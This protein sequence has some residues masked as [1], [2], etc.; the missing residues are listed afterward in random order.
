MSPIVAAARSPQVSSPVG[1]GRTEGSGEGTK[2]TVPT[3]IR[4][5]TLALSHGEREQRLAL[6]QYCVHQPDFVFHQTPLAGMPVRS[7]LRGAV[8]SFQVLSAL[9][10]AWKGSRDT[11]SPWPCW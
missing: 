4:S 1:R 2:L 8:S 6:N 5:L 7:T 11:N 10:T 3:P 9:L